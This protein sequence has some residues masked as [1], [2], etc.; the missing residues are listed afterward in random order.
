M[1]GQNGATDAEGYSIGTS[2]STALATRQAVLLHQM[3]EELNESL[4]DGIPEEYFPI[5][6]KAL[7]VH[8]AHWSD[9][10]KVYRE[11]I[12]RKSKR[13][14]SKKAYPS[15]F[16]LWQGK[17][18]NVA[19]FQRTTSHYTRIWEIGKG[20]SQRIFYPNTGGVEWY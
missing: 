14:S 18:R 3:L 12:G 11:D 13:K 6:L 7:L 8:G 20:N 16:G 10:D 17:R 5:M 2:N 1:P 9:A 19:L 15:I 4:S